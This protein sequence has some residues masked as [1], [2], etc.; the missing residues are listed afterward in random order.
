MKVTFNDELN[1]L[2]INCEKATGNYVLNVL[3]M[4]IKCLFW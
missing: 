4:N 1:P 3:Q 2:R